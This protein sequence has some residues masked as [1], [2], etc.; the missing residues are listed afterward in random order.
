MA[1]HPLGEELAP[2]TPLWDQAPSIEST[3]QVGRIYAEGG[4]DLEDCLQGDVLLTSLDPAQVREV[5]PTA[6]SQPFLREAESQAL[7]ADSPTEGQGVGV[8][9]LAR[10]GRHGPGSR[11]FR[12]PWI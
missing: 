3:D 11:S 9:G 10:A 1:H 12:R 4:T 7:L 8:G 2:S 6:I 5:D